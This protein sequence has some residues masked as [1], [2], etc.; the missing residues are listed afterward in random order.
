M[1]RPVPPLL[2]STEGEGQRSVDVDTRGRR[3]AVLMCDTCL[4]QYIRA[5]PVEEEAERLKK[6]RPS[7][8][9]GSSGQGQDEAVADGPTRSIA[10]ARPRAKGGGKRR[11]MLV[12][13]LAATAEKEG[14]EDMSAEEERAVARAMAG[15]W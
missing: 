14:L 3:A 2:P 8:S 1:S 7:A 5:G 6:L 13:S 4:T 11:M 15:E 9:R 10:A 12:A